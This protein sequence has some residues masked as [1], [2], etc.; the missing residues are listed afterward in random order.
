V[1]GQVQSN[2]AA[3]IDR[4][5]GADKDRTAILA[6]DDVQEGRP[7]VFVMGARSGCVGE[8]PGSRHRIGYPT[9]FDT[10]TPGAAIDQQHQGNRQACS[11]QCEEIALLDDLVCRTL[12]G[13]IH[14][15][16]HKRMIVSA[17]MNVSENGQ[18]LIDAFF[19]ALRLRDLGK[20]ESAL[21]QLAQFAEKSPQWQAWHQYLS[22][23]LIF[24]R[25]RDFAEAERVFNAVL[26]TEP[27]PN[28][29]GRVLRALGRSYQ[30]QG[31]WDAAVEV[32]RQSLDVF[33]VLEEP[34]EQAVAW[35]QM[36]IATRRGYNQG[37]FD[38]NVL[39]QALS[40]CQSALQVLTEAG[41]RGEAEAWL[42]GSIYNSLGAIHMQLGQWDDAIAAYLHDLAIC[43]TLD[44]RHG[45]GLTY[46]NLGEVYQ[47][48]GVAGRQEAL[49]AFEH[50]LALIAEFGNGYEEAEALANLAYYHQ[51]IGDLPEA[52]AYYARSV[53]MIEAMRTGISSSEVRSGYF[54]T[55]AD[56]Y[57]NLVN[58]C[59]QAGDVE[60][61][62]DTVERARARAF[63]DLLQSNAGDLPGEFGEEAVEAET[64]TLQDVQRALSKDALL[65][66]YFT[67]GMIEH[68]DERVR[69]VRAGR[70][71]RFPEAKTWLFAISSDAVVVH[72]CEL[73]PNH[74]LP[75]RIDEVVER[76]FLNENMRRMLYRKLI[77]TI[78]ST[79]W[80]KDRLYLA[81]H[82]P[83]HYLPFHALVA[84]DG[85]ALLRADGPTIA[86]SASAST[87]L[88][89]RPHREQPSAGTCLAV[90][91]NFG[92]TLQLQ[93]AEQEASL[94]AEL[95]GGT[96]MIG[97]ERMK[98]VLFNQ[99]VEYEMLHFSCHGEFLPDAPLES[100]LQIGTDERLTAHD[101][102]HHLRLNADLVMMSACESGLSRVRRGDELVGFTRSFMHAGARALIASLWRVDELST[103]FFVHALYRAVLAGADYASA[104][105]QAQLLMQS[106]TRKEVEEMLGQPIA[107][108]DSGERVFA[109]PFFWAP[110]VLFTSDL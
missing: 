96:T 85:Q 104:L 91:Y 101:V 25:D 92:E 12:T 40:Y 15:D 79:V 65:L 30:V 89:Q 70:R 88:H 80:E 78:E 22:G 8:W 48:Q 55:V 14:D 38:E 9:M 98:A 28:M 102:L 58:V 61:A 31:R 72:D 107:G 84:G 83:L 110:F 75:R 20:S 50:A 59:L 37:F 68:P 23:I 77:L 60:K 1:R 67:T 73:S 13:V 106:I 42:E 82:G 44:D 66:E 63:L 74:L 86:Y 108:G 11:N 94:V 71:H 34:V 57:A 64:V 103:S 100:Y 17:Q 56:I 26:D 105:Q 39:E 18:T 97:E 76:H 2:L 32:Y 54:E 52:I 19:S 29:R 35:K 33:E 16:P 47:K 21:A 109:Q 5:A 69:S 36:A 10:P 3:D 90:G 87:L 27:D 99:S 43:Q 51:S 41:E 45:M 46:G 93:F 62:F 6:G 4:R 95:M 7:G 49:Q 24:E 53:D 81:P